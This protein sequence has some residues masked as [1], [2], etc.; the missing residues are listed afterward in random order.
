MGYFG[1]IRGHFGDSCF[2]FVCGGFGKKKVDR[3]ICASF[4][5]FNK[6]TRIGKC[7]QSIQTVSGHPHITSVGCGVGVF[8]TRYT[9]KPE[10]VE[11]V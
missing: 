9:T 11:E 5:I 8:L 7:T 2:V 4:S 6:T 1:V 10:Q 3:T